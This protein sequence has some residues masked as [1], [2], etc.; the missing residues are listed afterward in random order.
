MR[1]NS[2][3]RPSLIKQSLLVSWS[4]EVH[5]HVCYV[6]WNCTRAMLSRLVCRNGLDKHDFCENIKSKIRPSYEAHS[7]LRHIGFARWFQRMESLFGG[8]WAKGPS[9]RDKC[10]C[11]FSQGRERSISMYGEWWGGK[12]AHID[13][14]VAHC[15]CR[16]QCWDQVNDLGGS[17]EN[18]L[19]VSQYCSSLE[20]WATVPSMGAINA[21]LPY[22]CTKRSPLTFPA[23]SRR[24]FPLWTWEKHGNVRLH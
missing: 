18:M 11:Q 14:F 9:V 23:V 22:N 2:S 21:L 7:H 20:R 4:L 24:T 19:N 12:L 8:N 5:V 6:R 16:V 1:R 3:V 13:R 10:P 17:P 15:A